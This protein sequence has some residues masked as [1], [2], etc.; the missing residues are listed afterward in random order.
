M[1]NREYDQFSGSTRR[2]QQGHDAPNLHEKGRIQMLKAL[3]PAAN[4][5]SIYQPTI[6]PGGWLELI[7]T[8]DPE[9]NDRIVN[10]DP[11]L[12]T[13]IADDF[14]PANS[15]PCVTRPAF[16]GAGFLPL[17]PY[18]G[19]V[20]SINGRVSV[21]PETVRDDRSYT[22]ANGAI[23]EVRSAPQKKMNITKS[24][25]DQRRSVNV[26]DLSRGPK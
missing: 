10:S 18:Y 5:K 1:A 20:P 2:A 11:Y 12:C 6:N 23:L 7:A 16:P 26:M 17:G 19:L 24:E 15:G 14:W 8:P 25:Q 3:I 21:T 22:K 9:V 4:G 13:H